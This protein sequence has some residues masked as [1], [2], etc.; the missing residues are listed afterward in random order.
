[1]IFSMRR[2][3]ATRALTKKNKEVSSVARRAAWV[4]GV[5]VSQDPAVGVD[6][7][8]EK[9]SRDRFELETPVLCL[10]EA[11]PQILSLVEEKVI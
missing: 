4:G 1:M 6:V 11:D 8:V 7:Q 10:A 3:T 9:L 5:I 2:P